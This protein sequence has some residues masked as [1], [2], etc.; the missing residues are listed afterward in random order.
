MILKATR[1]VLL[2]NTQYRTGDTLP[3][4]NELMVEAWL[5]AG[6]AVWTDEDETA[7]EEAAKAVPVTAP[8]G[9]PGLSSDG[10]PD[11]LI[12]R[13]PDKPPRKRSTRKKT[14]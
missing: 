8:P 1:P 4:D 11:A 12:G 10:D 2:R 13:V 6:S 9:Q 7:P 5:E 14:T 3:A